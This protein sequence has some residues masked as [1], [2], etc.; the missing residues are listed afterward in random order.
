[1]TPKISAALLL[2]LGLVGP[3]LASVYMWV[4]DDGVVHY[5]EAPPSNHKHVKKIAVPRLDE[6]TA[7]P[8]SGERQAAPVPAPKN[9]APP[10]RSSSPNPPQPR[11]LP[12]VELY[13]TSWCPWCKKARDFFSSRGIPFTEYDI[14]RDHE[15]YRRKMGLDGGTSIPTVVIGRK[16]IKG[17]SPAAYQ[18][19]LDRG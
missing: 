1:M 2:S 3:A 13:A 10:S 5:E 11:M 8:D 18:S 9:E 6:G 12:T 19:A 15:A 16:V 4:D 14:E 7:T 17:Y